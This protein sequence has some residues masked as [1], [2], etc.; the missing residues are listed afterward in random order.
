M[1]C[2]RKFTKVA[3]AMQA[4]VAEIVTKAGADVVPPK[5]REGKRR[6]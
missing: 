2:R 5:I 3:R 4:L 1:I 6:V